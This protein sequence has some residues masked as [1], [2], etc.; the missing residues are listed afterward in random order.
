MSGVF[1]SIVGGTRTPRQYSTLRTILRTHLADSF[2]FSL[3]TGASDKG[4]PL[5]QACSP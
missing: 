1:D 2:A 4:K 3:P 5:V